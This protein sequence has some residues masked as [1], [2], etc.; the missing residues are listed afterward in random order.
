[1][2]TVGPR[3][4]HA[5]FVAKKSG[6]KARNRGFTLIEIAIVLVIVG[7]I[8]GGILSAR[9][10]IRNA[11]T[12]DV[13]KS[14][15]DISIVAQ[16]FRDRYGG[17]PGDLLNAGGV[18]ASL[19]PACN[20]NI[21]PLGNGVIDPGEVSC[22]VEELIRSSM[23]RGDAVAGVVTVGSTSLTLTSRTSAAALPGLGTLPASWL[24]VV[25]VQN[26]D[27]DI[28]IQIDRAL[29]DGNTAQGNF[30]TGTACPTQDEEVLIT[31]AVLR[32]N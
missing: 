6:R 7:L 8:F 4:M 28:A 14:V 23:L 15:S 18:L 21:A 13:I 17:L 31:D 27:C 9:S 20:G 19:T 12:K 22:A 26:I 3:A 25:R 5:L 32:L 10:V 24:N 1:M 2:L 16:Q 29:D 11:K 30:R